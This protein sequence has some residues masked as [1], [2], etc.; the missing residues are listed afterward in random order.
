[1]A[2]VHHD[3]KDFGDRVGFNHIISGTTQYANHVLRVHIHI[4]DC[5]SYRQIWSK[6]FEYRITVSNLFHLQDEICQVIT[7]QASA[8]MPFNK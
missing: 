3:L 2:P 7:E 1:M 5:R 8:L 4:T 6:V